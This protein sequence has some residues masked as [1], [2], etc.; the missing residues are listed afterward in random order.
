[1]SGKSFH[2][3]AVDV[4]YHRSC[5][6][7]FPSPYKSKETVLGKA[8]MVKVNLL[9]NKDSERFLTLVERK[10]IKDKEAYF[11]TDFPEVIENMNTENGLQES[12][13]KCTHEWKSKL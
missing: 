12:C 4:Y 1:M 10:V 6:L 5:Y 13:I 9:K 8:E 3:F 2:V 7:S 11:M